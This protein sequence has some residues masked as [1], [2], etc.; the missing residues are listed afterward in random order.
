MLPFWKISHLRYL[1]ECL[2]RRANTPQIPGFATSH[3]VSSW[4]RAQA[5]WPDF[6]AFGWQS[7]T[8][9]LPTHNV[10]SWGRVFPAN[11]ASQTNQNI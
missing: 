5:S 8:A 11:S 1:L 10:A 7:W 6:W 9:R 3:L 2:L 4:H